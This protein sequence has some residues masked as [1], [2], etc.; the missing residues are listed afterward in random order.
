MQVQ[1]GCIEKPKPKQNL[2]Q[3]KNTIHNVKNAQ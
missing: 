2:Q 3:Q 1:K